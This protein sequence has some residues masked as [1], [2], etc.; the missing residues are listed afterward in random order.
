MLFPH[1]GGNMETI[2]IGKAIIE[3]DVVMPTYGIP[4]ATL[5]CM[6]R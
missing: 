5:E 4:K 3:P 1:K 6:G 2:I